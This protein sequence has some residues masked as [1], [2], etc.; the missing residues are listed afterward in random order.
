MPAPAAPPRPDDVAGPSDGTSQ[1]IKVIT[2]DVQQ[3]HR[4]APTA[5]LAT[6]LHAPPLLA[7]PV[8]VRRANAVSAIRDQLFVHAPTTLG[9]IRLSLGFAAGGKGDSTDVPGV[10]VKD[11]LDNAAGGNRAEDATGNPAGDAAKAITST[12]SNFNFDP[13]F[14]NWQWDPNPNARDGAPTWNLSNL[15]P[16]PTPPD[17]SDLPR[18]PCDY[19]PGMGKDPG[20]REPDEPT[21][22]PSDGRT[23]DEILHPGGEGSNESAPSIDELIALDS[24][25]ASNTG[26]NQ[27]NPDTAALVNS[28]T[29]DSDKQPPA[30]NQG[31]PDNNDS[32]PNP[33][34][35]D[36]KHGPPRPAAYPKPD[37]G[38]G[39]PAGI[40]ASAHGLMASAFA[41]HAR[42]TDL[43]APSTV[44][45]LSQAEAHT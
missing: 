19:T 12:L 6:Q 28:V 41:A 24:T 29:D 35:D 20:C 8:A 17:N 9:P 10:T 40:V 45:A 13:N 26:S 31:K 38:I 27:T 39:G 43:G 11:T 30:D 14:R 34:S 15:R 42:P 7:G 33:D 4:K 32:T 44:T 23:L 5:L 37:G 25:S 16:G 36:G 22:P 18:G 21:L 1:A 3:P 2:H